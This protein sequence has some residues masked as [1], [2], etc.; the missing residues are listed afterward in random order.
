MRLAVADPKLVVAIVIA[1]ELP[2][3]ESGG[4][5]RGE[6]LVREQL[7]RTRSTWLSPFTSAKAAVKVVTV[8]L[9]TS[10]LARAVKVPAQTPA[11]VKPSFSH[12]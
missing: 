1:H 11:H 8:E 7:E 12:S 9:T 6:G 4:A 5:R 10:P 2:S 3:D